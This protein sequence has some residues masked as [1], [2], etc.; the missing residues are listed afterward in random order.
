MLWLVWKKQ[1]MMFYSNLDE[2]FSLALEQTI[3]IVSFVTNKY[4][5]AKGKGQQK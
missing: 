3:F 4:K 1:G 5:A 2:Q